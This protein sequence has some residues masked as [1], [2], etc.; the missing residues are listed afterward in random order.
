M[1]AL[2]EQAVQMIRC[3]PDE[4]VRF[5]IRILTGLTRTAPAAP[6]ARDE[7][8][9]ETFRSVIREGLD[10]IAAGRTIPLEEA[11]EKLLEGV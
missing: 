2:Q 4:D 1:S 10:D 6:L 5:V 9:D 11:F 8:D 7:M 3:L